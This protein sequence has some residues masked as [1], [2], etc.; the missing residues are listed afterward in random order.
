MM[1]KAKKQHL[2]DK[3]KI[4]FNESLILTAL[5]TIKK[6]KN[7]RKGLSKFICNI[8]EHCQKTITSNTLNIA[9]GYRLIEFN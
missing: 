6:S 3:K 7:Y 4:E 8:I 1:E 5:N 2:L 9:T